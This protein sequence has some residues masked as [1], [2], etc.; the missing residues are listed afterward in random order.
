MHL[1]L[2][3]FKINYSILIG[4][5]NVHAFLP[6]IISNE[7]YWSKRNRITKNN[8]II[9]FISIIFIDWISWAEI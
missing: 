5:V 1:L 6:V 8:F 9:Y 3:Y 7:C 2:I 4:A